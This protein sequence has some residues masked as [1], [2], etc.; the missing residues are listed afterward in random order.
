[1][2]G[3]GNVEGI[4]AKLARALEHLGTLDDQLGTYLDTSPFEI[5]RQIQPDGETSVFALQVRRPPPIELSVIVGEVA[6]QLRSAVEHIAFGLV[7]AAGNAPTDRTVFPVLVKR[8]ASLRI[9]GGVTAEALEIVDRVQPY[10][11]LDAESHPLHVLH[12]LW[13]VDK[14]RSLH[15]TALLLRESQI[16]L[17]PSDGSSMVGGQFQSGPLGHEGIIGVFRFAGGTA[18]PDMEVLASGE[19]FV[20]LGDSGPWP[21]DRPVLLVLEELIKYVSMTLVPMFEPHLSDA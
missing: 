7:L 9:E 12:R 17:S 21:N 5:Q 15:L 2:V 20:A 1:M 11:Q 3:M 8:P 16:F 10:T 6:H 4:R 13:N 14:H 18:D 19:T